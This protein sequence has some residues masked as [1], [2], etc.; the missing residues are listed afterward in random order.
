[1]SQRFLTALR[2]TLEGGNGLDEN[3]FKGLGMCGAWKVLEVLRNLNILDRFICLQTFDVA[4]E[5]P[6]ADFFLE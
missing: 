3:L 2:L 4:E 5:F 1:V 6:I